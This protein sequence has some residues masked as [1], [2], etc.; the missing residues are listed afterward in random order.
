MELD[1]SAD[2]GAAARCSFRFNWA[3]NEATALI[4]GYFWFWI[5]NVGPIYL[6]MVPAALSMRKGGAR[7]GCW[8]W[9]RCCIYV[10]AEMI[11][12][13]AE[14][15]T[16]TTSCSMWRSSPCCPWRG[17]IWRSSGDA[18][19]GVRGRAL[20]AAAF[21]V[22][23]L[24]SGTLS[25]ARET[26][27]DYQLF[28]ADQA[29]AAEY[30][31][32]NTPE[33]AMILT[34]DAAQQPHRRADGAVHRLRNGELSAFPRG[35]LCA[36]SAGRGADAGAARGERG[37]V[38]EVRRG[39]CVSVVARAEQLRRG[40][41]MVS[42]KRDGGLRGLRGDG[43]CAER[44]A[45]RLR[46][47]RTIRRRVG[48][49]LFRHLRHAASSIYPPANLRN[50]AFASDEKSIRRPT[51]SFCAVLPKNI[52]DFIESASLPLGGEGDTILLGEE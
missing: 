47:H 20:L 43:L 45:G 38:R 41:G 23:C 12:F 39:V 4:D 42:G 48:L 19:K 46:Q 31:E 2:G 29:A 37:A 8:P 7:R 52:Y 25:L 36:E 24:L 44:G 50:S 13:P 21:M 10:A 32:E 18:L 27:S 51:A 30:V 14:R 5:K 22:V 40:R 35:G 15:Y 26:I 33:K 16:T 9:A 6:L 11:Q 1:V 34:G 3:N 28:S 17:G 49:C